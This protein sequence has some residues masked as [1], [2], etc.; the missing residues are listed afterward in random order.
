[1]C[2]EALGKLE[3]ASQ[4]LCTKLLSPAPHLFIKIEHTREKKK[5]VEKQREEGH[6]SVSYRPPVDDHHQRQRGVEATLLER[7]WATEPNLTAFVTFPFKE[8]KSCLR[9]LQRFIFFNS[10][11]SSKWLWNRRLRVVLKLASVPPLPALGQPK[12]CGEHQ[13]MGFL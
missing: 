4:I 10:S 1:M 2:G 6:V 12:G 7:V 5:K 8:Q 13:A 9:L 11:R 3:C